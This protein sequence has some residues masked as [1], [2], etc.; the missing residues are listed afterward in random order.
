[1]HG[2]WST[3]GSALHRGVDDSRTIP[4]TPSRIRL[5]RRAGHRPHSQ[6]IT[7]GLLCLAAATVLDT[8]VPNL[9]VD[10]F[11]SLRHAFDSWSFAAVSLALAGMVATLASALVSGQLGWVSPRLSARLHLPN[12]AHSRSGPGIRLI[13][14]L[15]VSLVVIA[16][17]LPLVA[18]ATRAVDASL[19]G[20]LTLW[21]TWCINMLFVTGA[22]ATLAGI[23]DLQAAFR[24]LW[25]LLHRS[26][27]EIRA[28]RQGSTRR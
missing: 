22:V 2:S 12:T 19:T 18:G 24:R 21:R 9:H 6:W 4:P 5:A 27:A 11:T 3:G 26:V 14:G 15:V 1:M 17:A 13:L 8:E 16:T 25:W 7:T 23:F 28:A 20:L 10:T